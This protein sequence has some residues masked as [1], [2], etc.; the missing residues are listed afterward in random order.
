MT[1]TN[2]IQINDKIKMVMKYPT[3]DSFDPNTNASKLKTEQLFDIIADTVFMKFMM[4]KPCIMV[5]IIV[6][7]K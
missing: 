7:K 2:E 3:I 5:V 6:K 1:N 4:V